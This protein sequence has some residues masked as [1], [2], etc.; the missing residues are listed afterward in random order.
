M[1]LLNILIISIVEGITEF[2]PI[3]STAHMS[4]TAKLLGLANTP[5]LSSFMI[6]IQIGALFA[7][8]IF[9]LRK[10][11]LTKLVF[12][13]TVI[14]FVPTAIIG[15]LVY[16]V[17]K[18]YLLGNIVVIGLA[19]LIG[20]IVILLVDKKASPLSNFS[21]P[22]LPASE[23]GVNSP[24]TK[25]SASDFAN[26]NKELSYKNAFILGI[27][28]ALAFVPGVSRSGALII[29]GRLLN[30]KRE[31]IVIFTFLLGL[32]TLAAATLYD[33]YKS[34]SILSANLGFDI[35]IGAIISGIVAYIV[36]NWFLKYI[37]NHTFKFFG[38]YR[39]VLGI[40]L[41]IFFV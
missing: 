29:G 14:A 23:V 38:W 41:L 15:F 10:V 37:T 20:G 6:A 32:P 27:V 33:L 34:K 36:A 25:I 2:L 22:R 16:P 5:A 7:G 11:K 26:V 31:D 39:I 9:I 17:I 24:D 18:H 21:G 28:Q 13:N 8:A 3:S 12:I 35:L 1:T 19:L 40:L 30:Y 4:I